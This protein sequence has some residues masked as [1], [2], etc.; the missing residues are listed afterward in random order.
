MARNKITEYDANGVNWNLYPIQPDYQPGCQVNQI[1]ATLPPEYPRRVNVM[2]PSSVKHIYGVMPGVPSPY[3][4]EWRIE[5]PPMQQAIPYQSLYSQEWDTYNRYGVKVKFGFMPWPLHH[6]S[7]WE[8]REY[9]D[10]VIPLLDARA[11]TNY[12]TRTE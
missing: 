12:T 2:G 8:V 10:R 4:Q 9:S 3:A 6:Q 7:N 11:L 5:R 1:Y